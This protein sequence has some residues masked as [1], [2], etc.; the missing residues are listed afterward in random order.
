[1]PAMVKS[2]LSLLIDIIRAVCPAEVS[3]IEGGDAF[4]VIVKD[5]KNTRWG[6]LGTNVETGRITF[7]TCDLARAKSMKDTVWWTLEDTGMILSFLTG[8]IAIQK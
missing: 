2:S 4:V 5:G 3:P 1:M 8:T 7:A 6:I